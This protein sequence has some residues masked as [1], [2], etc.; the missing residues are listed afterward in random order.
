M[1]EEKIYHLNFVGYW[2]DENK[3]N[4]PSIS[5]V[6][7]VYRCVYNIEG[8]TVS[9]KEIIYIGQS[10]NIKNEFSS[11][12]KANEFKETLLKGEDLCYSCAFVERADLDIVENALIYAQEPPLN[13]VL[14]DNY[15]HDTASF[16]LTGKCKLMKHIKFR[17]TRGGND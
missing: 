14:K 11:H 3:A 2:R 13:G 9:L 12:A 7:L 1:A 10:Y 15:N 4:L 5:G 8:N 16:A 6:Y 17:I